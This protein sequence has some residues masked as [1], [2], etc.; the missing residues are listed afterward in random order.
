M[1]WY[2]KKGERS[3]MVRLWKMFT[4]KSKYLFGKNENKKNLLIK[5]L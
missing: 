1:G 4:V 2:A 5:K 3:Q